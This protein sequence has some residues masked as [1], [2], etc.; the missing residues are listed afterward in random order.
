MAYGPI[1][2]LRID[3]ETGRQQVLLRRMIVTDDA[4]DPADKDEHE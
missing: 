2:C 1:I 3:V 4:D